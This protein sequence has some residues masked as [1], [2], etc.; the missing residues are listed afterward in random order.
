MREIEQLAPAVPVRQSEERV[1]AD[2]P[3][4]RPRAH[5]RRATPRVS[6][7]CSSCRRA[8][9][10]ADRRRARET[11]LARARASRVDR[12][13]RRAARRDAAGRRRGSAA[14][15]AAR[16]RAGRRRRD[17]SVRSEPDRTCRPANRAAHRRACA[18]YHA[19]AARARHAGDQ[20]FRVVDFHFDGAERLLVDHFGIAQR[21]QLGALGAKRRET[22]PPLGRRQIVESSAARSVGRVAMKFR[23][24]SRRSAGLR[25]R[26]PRRAAAFGQRAAEP[27]STR[28][29]IPTIAPRAP[30]GRAPPSA[31]NFNVRIT[32]G[33]VSPLISSVSTIVAAARKH[34]QVAR[35]KRCA[36]GAARTAI[37]SAAASVTDPRRPAQPTEENGSRIVPAFALADAPR[38]GGAAGTRAG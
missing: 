9:S 29:A 34:D 22:E 30:R 2:D 12:R 3:Q 5:P 38:T 6:A 36:V 14:L 27:R 26:S 8:G 1:G 15:P 25:T 7:P 16:A 35:G 23:A 11:R 17:A 31:R 10:R 20:R 18:G 37:D 33:S 28:L 32:T 19:M 24:R 13:R 21:V 4:Q